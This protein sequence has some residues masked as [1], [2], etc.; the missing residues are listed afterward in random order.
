MVFS[1]CI[2]LFPRL[3]FIELI[4][5]KLSFVISILITFASLNIWLLILFNW[6]ILDDRRSMFDDFFF[7]IC[8]LWIVIFSQIVPP[9]LPHDICNMQPI[10]C[11]MFLWFLVSAPG[12]FGFFVDLF[13][14]IFVNWF[15]VLRFY[16]RFRDF[17]WS[18]LTVKNFQNKIRI[19]EIE[20]RWKNYQKFLTTAPLYFVNVKN[21]SSKNY[22]TLNLKYNY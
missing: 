14:F 16:L 5:T 9:H 13:H 2:E 7:K 8:F 17:I 21:R 12:S 10:S 3:I 11:S 22:F 4:F 6:W 15:G 18:W 20:A 1:R 19:F